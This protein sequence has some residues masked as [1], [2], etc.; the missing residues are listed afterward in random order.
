MDIDYG[1]NFK[2]S[3]SFEADHYHPVSTHPH[4]ALAM[5][6]LRP[7][8]QSCNRSRGNKAAPGSWARADW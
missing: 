3:N 8:H 5:G 4:L 7:S 1:A 6:N 2:Q